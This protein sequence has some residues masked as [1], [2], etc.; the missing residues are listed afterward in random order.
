MVDV[1]NCFF[2]FFTN[3]AIVMAHSWQWGQMYNIQYCTLTPMFTNFPHDAISHN[4]E[5]G[6]HYSIDLI[7]MIEFN[8]LNGVNAKEQININN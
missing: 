2:F 8:F 5:Q 7:K 3:Y 6:K 4:V 1:T